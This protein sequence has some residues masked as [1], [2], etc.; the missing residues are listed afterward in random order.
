M[1]SYN[2]SIPRDGLVLHLDA[3]N[4]KC[5][6]GTGLAINDLTSY[7]TPFAM[8]SEGLYVPEDGVFRFEYKSDGIINNWIHT[9]NF[10]AI[11]TGD[12]L[13]FTYLGFIKVTDSGSAKWWS[14]DDL[15]ADTSNRLNFYASTS[16]LS[17]EINNATNTK[18][19][20]IDLPLLNNWTFCGYRI[21]EDGLNHTM[22]GR[23]FTVNETQYSTN[24][25][26]RTATIGTHILFG[27]RGLTQAINVD[28]IWE[29]R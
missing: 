1:I 10:S 25:V 9:K 8:Q 28:W 26:T 16:R 13:E 21:D 20:V 3:V 24:T 7:R 12:L 27:R 15:G 2:T 23:N 22:I 17:S 11:P 6:P 4:S 18:V 14:F 19:P 29:F 5:Y